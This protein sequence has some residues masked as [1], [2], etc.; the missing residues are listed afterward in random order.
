MKQVHG[1]TVQ[2]FPSPGG[3]GDAAFTRKAG[4][5]CAVK[6]AD[7]MPVLFTD[8]AASVVGVAHAGWRGMSGGV[9]ENTIRAMGVAPAS[10]LAWMGPAISGRAYEVGEDV[11][12]A[13]AAY[14][15]AFAPA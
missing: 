6:V 7:C 15:E 10:L 11:K 12:A 3:D 2:E 9:L 13:F 14:P 5:V 8:D 4:V 1:V